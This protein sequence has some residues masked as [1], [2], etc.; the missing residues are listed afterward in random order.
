VRTS[1]LPP[2]DLPAET[3]IFW[4]VTVSDQTNGVTG[5]PSS[6]ASFN[7]ALAIDLTKVVYLNS[8][9]IAGWRQTGNLT[10]VEQDGGGDGPMCMSFSDPGWPNSHWPF[11]G[12]DPDFGVYGNQWYFAKINGRWYAGAGEWLYRGAATCNAWV[13]KVGE[14]VGFA[15]TSVARPGVQRTVDERTNVVVQPWRDTSLGS[16]ILGRLR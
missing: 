2:L 14:L 4:R 13:P 8:P 9:D 12:P 3:D 16:R 11:G 7:T 1:F 6:G 15:V 10:L 5:P